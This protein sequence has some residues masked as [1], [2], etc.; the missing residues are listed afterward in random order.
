MAWLVAAVALQ[1]ATVRAMFVVTNI[2][3]MKLGGVREINVQVINRSAAVWSVTAAE[4]SCSCVSVQE[5]P[6]MLAPGSSAVVRIVLH[7]EMPGGFGYVINLPDRD[8]GD[9]ACKI[10]IN[11][12]VERDVKEAVGNRYSACGHANDR[13]IRSSR[14]NN[15]PFIH[16]RRVHAA[17]DR[18]RSALICV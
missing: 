18:G 3:T 5:W 16:C 8:R 2:G 14:S 11:V 12:T 10:I 4:C 17:A 13:V 7:A 9:A 6:R 15:R 1:A